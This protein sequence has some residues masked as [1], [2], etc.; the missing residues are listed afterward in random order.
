MMELANKSTL[1]RP[2]TNKQI[3]V[4]TVI[5]DFHD[6]KG[7]PPTLQDISAR[8]EVST[9]TA[10]GHVDRLIR[11]GVLSRDGEGRRTLK[12]LHVE[13]LAARAP[14]ANLEDLA[15]EDLVAEIK[16]RGFS[17]LPDILE[18]AEPEPEPEATPE[19]VEPDLAVAHA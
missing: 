11:K 14:K 19:P 6:E 7:Y 13:F 4:L 15:T 10:Q 9:S 16:N 8:L 2:L 5:A 12:I 18:K 1:L 17:V 3:N